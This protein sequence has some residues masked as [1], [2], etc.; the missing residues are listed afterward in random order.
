MSTILIIVLILVVFGGGGGWYGYNRYG[1]NGLGG[2]LGLVL[3][4]L[5]IAYLLGGLRF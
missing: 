3:F 5:L 1:Y 2:A 4:I